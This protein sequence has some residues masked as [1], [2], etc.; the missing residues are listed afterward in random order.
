MPMVQVNPIHVIERQKRLQTCQT[1]HSVEV[2]W[3]RADDFVSIELP[4]SK[5]DSV[6]KEDEEKKVLTVPSNSTEETIDLGSFQ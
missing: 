1:C 4:V 6:E 5:I 3:N 2:V